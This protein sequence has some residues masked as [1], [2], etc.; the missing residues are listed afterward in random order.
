MT[1]L[2]LLAKT[3]VAALAYC[4]ARMHLLLEVLPKPSQRSQGMTIPQYESWP[5]R[6]LRYELLRRGQRTLCMTSATTLLD[7]YCCLKEKIIESY[8]VRWMVETLFGELKT[9]L[10]MRRV[11]SQTAESIRKELAG[12]VLVYNLVSRVMLGMTWRQGVQGDRI[13]FVDTIRWL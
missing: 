2:R 8:K 3:A 6:A 10:K 9:T 5:V 12:H 11:K 13:C 7:V 4:H 1:H